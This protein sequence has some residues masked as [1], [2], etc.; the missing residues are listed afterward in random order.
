MWWKR[1]CVECKIRD[2][3]I[4]A[5]LEEK[6]NLKGLLKEARD[7]EK[8]AIDTLLAHQGKSPVTTHDLTQ[9]QADQIM[10][11]FAEAGPKKKP[12]SAGIFEDLHHRETG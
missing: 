12:F 10:N 11:P 4:E 8:I 6:I 7:R 2:V 9:E 1:E 5:L 3:R